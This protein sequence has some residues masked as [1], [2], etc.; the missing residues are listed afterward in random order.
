MSEKN[1][2]FVIQLF[3]MPYS[4]RSEILKCEHV[5][6]ISQESLIDKHA[7]FGQGTL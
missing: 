2:H 7:S 5:W 3:L 6:K 1:Q 4:K